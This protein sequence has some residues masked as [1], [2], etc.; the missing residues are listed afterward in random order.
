MATAR[1]TMATMTSRR[2]RYAAGNSAAYHAGKA[3]KIAMPPVTSHTSSAS[4]TGPMAV[5]I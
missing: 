4:H 1:T 3:A 2:G 5:S